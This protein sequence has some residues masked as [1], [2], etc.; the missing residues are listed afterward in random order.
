M[1]AIKESVSRQ[2]MS[3]VFQNAFTGNTTVDGPY[4]D[5]R[6]YPNGVYFGFMCTDHA[7]GVYTCK[8]EHSDEAGTGFEAV[9]LDN[10]V[11]GRNADTVD[12]AWPVLY[13]DT[14]LIDVTPEVAS[15]T[16]ITNDGNGLATATTSVAHKLSTGQVITIAGADQSEYNGT[17]VVTV[18]DENEFYYKIPGAPVSATGTITGTYDVLGN[19]VRE[20]IVGQKRYVRV[21]VTSTGV[22]S[23]ATIMAI[24][25]RNPQNIPVYAGG[26]S[27]PGAI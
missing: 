4:I 21:S 6:E 16:A 23:G 5:T 2:A 27:S 7:D 10:L 15:I 22:T 8:I 18:K 25:V 26:T 12:D 13:A 24:A 14:P 1:G 9:D 11:L 20:G 3:L 17:F 19:I